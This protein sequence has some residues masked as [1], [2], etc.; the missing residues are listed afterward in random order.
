MRNIDIID[1]S[2]SN[3]VCLSKNVIFVFSFTISDEFAIILMNKIKFSRKLINFIN[4]YERK[5]GKIYK[6][7]K[8]FKFFIETNYVI[9]INRIQTQ[10]FINIMFDYIVIS[11]SFNKIISGS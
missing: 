2:S 9:Q 8:F 5:K 3:D 4:K 11:Y 10:I 6:I 1:T 7:C